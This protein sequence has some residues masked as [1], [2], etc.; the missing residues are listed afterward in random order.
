[1]EATEPITL[2]QYG[3]MAEKHWREFRP[4]MVR[5]LEATGKLR[6]RLCE[7]QE[8]TQ[9]AMDTLTEK[10]LRQG[11]TPQQAETAAWE[12]IREEYILLPPENAKT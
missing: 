2:S 1:M 10:L 11:Y 8:A 7:A 3:L 9:N 6:E 4:T 12:L 5:E